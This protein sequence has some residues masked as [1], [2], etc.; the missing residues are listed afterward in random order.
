MRH[1][2]GNIG[3]ALKYQQRETREPGAFP[4]AV[5]RPS[6]HLLSL[7]AHGPAGVWLTRLWAPLAPTSCL[8]LT[9]TEGAKQLLPPH[10]HQLN[11][12]ASTEAGSRAGHAAP[13]ALRR[14]PGQGAGRGH[15]SAGGGRLGA[16]W[17]R[18]WEGSHVRREAEF[19]QTTGPPGGEPCGHGARRQAVRPQEAPK[20]QQAGQ[21]QH[22]APGDPTP[23]CLL[24]RPLRQKRLS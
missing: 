5:W 23:A 13:G 18:S 12:L 10:S 22:W 20:T 21:A 4:S 8:P 2:A 19:G 9:R 24:A 6:E 7:Q 1:N 14:G 15:S 17:V 3:Y 16:G 11:P